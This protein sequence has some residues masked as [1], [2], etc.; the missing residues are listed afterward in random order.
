MGFKRVFV[1]VPARVETVMSVLSYGHFDYVCP[2]DFSIGNSSIIYV[3]YINDF[4][5]YKMGSSNQVLSRVSLWF[6]IQCNHSQFSAQETHRRK[7]RWNQIT[8]GKP[9]KAVKCLD[10]P[11]CPE[12][13]GLVPQCGSLVGADA[14]VECVQCKP[15]ETY[16]DKHDFSSCKPCTICDPNEEKI[17]P[18][19]ETKNAVCGKCNAGYVYLYYRTDTLTDTFHLGT[20]LLR[21]RSEKAWPHTYTL[22]FNLLQGN[23]SPRRYLF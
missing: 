5:K 8:L 21:W 18:C 2:S 22:Y 16:S 9:G 7:C 17:S 4:W 20:P 1:N 14:N 13:L 12:G 23:T 6:L 19:T 15:G 3:N 10:C 11:E